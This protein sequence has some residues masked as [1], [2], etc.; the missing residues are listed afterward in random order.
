MPYDLH[1]FVRDALAAKQPRARI[2]QA[3]E[4]AGWP[5]DEVR[6][7]LAA[8]ADVDFALPVPRRKPYLSA[9]EAF[10]YLLLFTCLYISAWSLGSLL[11]DFVNRGLPDPLS[12]GYY[13]QDYLSSIRLATSALVITF[14]VFMWLS[15]AARQEAKA[16]SERESSRVRKWLTYLTLFGAAGTIIG[17]LITLLYNLLEG[18]LTLRFGLKVL[19]VL[20]IAVSIFGYYLWDL[21]RD[22]KKTGASAKTTPA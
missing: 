6:T 7:A 2:A 9:R 1:D 3:L 10:I 4:S 18:E 17:D 15:Y 14:P 22:E 5:A 21:R 8:Y 20:A 19:I 16:D 11:F 12:D 13:G